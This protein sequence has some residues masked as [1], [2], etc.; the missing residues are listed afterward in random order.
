M[1]RIKLSYEQKEE[2]ENFRRQASSKNSEKALMILLNNEGRS[3]SEISQILKRHYHTVRTWLKRYELSGITGLE[4]NFSPG[5][6]PVL[7]EKVKQCIKEMINDSA[8]GNEHGHRT[9]SVS[10]ITFELN[11]KFDVSHDTVRRSLK[12]MGYVFKRPSETVPGHAPSRKIKQNH[13]KK[14][15]MISRKF[16][17]VGKP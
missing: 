17:L 7:R 1:F 8:P 3:I 6:P 9:W 4:R 12:D 5:R 16:P 2:L 14:C 15:S 11:R 13:I 10:L